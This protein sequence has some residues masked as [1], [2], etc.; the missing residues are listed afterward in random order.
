MSLCEVTAQFGSEEELAQELEKNLC[1]GG[2]FIK[3]ASD[4]KEND[5]TELILVH[6]AVAEEIR[7]SSRVVMFTRWDMNPGVA[8]LI[9]DFCPDKREA[10]ER[11][12]RQEGGAEGGP[13]PSSMKS[14]PPKTLHERLRGLSVP[15]QRK[16][17]GSR[18]VNERVQLERI[19]G[20]MV[21]EPILRNPLVTV[22]EVAR[23][24]KM[25]SLPQPLFDIIGANNAFL[26]VPQ[27]RRALLSNPKTPHSLVDKVLRLAPRQ[28]L[29]LIP[30]Q[31]SYTR[32]V[33]EK[34]KK[35]LMQG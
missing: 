18:D 32:V 6:P 15:E 21:W 24:A 10:L 4:L 20:K 2:M 29:K 5:H 34:A 13:G 7:L 19:Y 22:P 17:A 12:V 30:Q 14:V 3:G 8:E 23:I 31:P 33:K 26:K 9:Y 28:E 27:V 25:G 35:L 11:F 1:H 16:V